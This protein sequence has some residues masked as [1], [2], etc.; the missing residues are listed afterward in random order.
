MAPIYVA[1]W[2]PIHVS[3]V[4]PSAF[5]D[6]FRGRNFERRKKQRNRIAEMRSVSPPTHT[7]PPLNDIAHRGE[8][9]REGVI[10]KVNKLSGLLRERGP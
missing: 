2:T 8:R 9:E 7:T 6:F 1:L 4:M 3:Y 10:A 5:A